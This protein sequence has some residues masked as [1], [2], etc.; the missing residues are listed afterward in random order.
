MSATPRQQHRWRDVRQVVEQLGMRRRVTAHSE[1]AGCLHEGLPEMVHPDSIHEHTCRQRVFRTRHRISQ[2]HP[3]ASL[4]KTL[5]VV[6]GQNSQESP[7][8]RLPRLTEI[9]PN[10]DVHISRTTFG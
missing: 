1:I 9:S 6:T 3:S 5:R 10:C 8:G 7:R 4:G 2:L